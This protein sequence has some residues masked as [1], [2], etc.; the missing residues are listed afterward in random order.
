M[1]T[2]PRRDYET[3]ED[4]VIWNS[5]Q[6]FARVF[7]VPVFFHG[8]FE[9]LRKRLAEP[10]QVSCVGCGCRVECGVWSVQ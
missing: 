8:S 5:L 3:G 10:G 7:C 6:L 4:V 1:Q 2:S 9:Q